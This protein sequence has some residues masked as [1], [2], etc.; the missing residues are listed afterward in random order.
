MAV[1]K[2]DVDFLETPATF[3]AQADGDLVALNAVARRLV[4]NAVG[5]KCWHAVGGLSDAEG[6]PCRFGCVRDL[7][8][9]GLEKTQRT[10]IRLRNRCHML[11]CVP[12]DGMV[13]CMLS[14]SSDEHP[15]T[16]QLLTTREREVLQLLSE[17]KNTA[18][19]AAQLGLGE[20]TVRT[21]VEHMRAKLGVSTR[22][23][24]VARG[25]EL[26]FLG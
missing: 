17:D 15:Q 21:H 23:A 16:W 14:P 13:A 4:G 7:M 9:Q 3:V 22:A 19:I 25:Y 10:R 6:L 26:G 18:A 2:Q 5:R 8:N 12:L 1:V 11:T 24:L 20:T